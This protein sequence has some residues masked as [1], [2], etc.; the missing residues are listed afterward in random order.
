[1]IGLPTLM[2]HLMGRRITDGVL[3]P[4][5][6]ARAALDLYRSGATEWETAVSRGSWPCQLPPST[7]SRCYL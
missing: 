6:N 5:E 2:W 3:H 4:L 7:Y 1:M